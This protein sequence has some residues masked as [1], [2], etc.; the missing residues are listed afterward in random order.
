M[1]GKQNINNNFLKEI[2]KKMNI[3]VQHMAEDVAFQ[4][5]EIYESAIQMFYEDY[6]PRYYQRTYSTYEASSGAHSPL[7]TVKAIDN[8]YQGGIYVDPSYI[9]GNPYRASKDWVLPR[10]FVEGIH[11]MTQFEATNWWSMR[12]DFWRDY[13]WNSKAKSYESYLKSKTKNIPKKMRRN[14]GD[15]KLIFLAE[16]GSSKN[17]ESMQAIS[18]KGFPTAPKKLADKEFKKLTKK[19]N[20]KAISDKWISSMFNGS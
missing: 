13:M 19:R 4:I 15:T 20:L 9:E 7:D 10:T 3:A 12:K 5:E 14:A 17:L 11:G 8:G 1:N 2:K 18:V 16:N 6:A